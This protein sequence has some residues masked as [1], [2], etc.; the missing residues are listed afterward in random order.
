MH[1]DEKKS[2]KLKPGEEPKKPYCT[3]WQDVA[4]TLGAVKPQYP[5]PQTPKSTMVG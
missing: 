5:K 2:R 1:P 3:N 4:R